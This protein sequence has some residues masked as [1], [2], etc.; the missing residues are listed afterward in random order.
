MKSQLGSVIH[1]DIVSQIFYVRGKKVMIDSDLASLYG[2]ETKVLNQAVKRNLKRFPEDFCFQL[3]S[4]EWSFLRSQFVTL[5]K[6]SLDKELK[7]DQR[8][9]FR[10]YLPFVFTEHGTLMLASVLQS[11]VA[12]NASIFVVRAFIKLREFLEINKDLK[13]KVETLEAKYDK[14]FMLLFRA[15]K[16][17]VQ[18]KNDPLAP[19]GFRIERDKK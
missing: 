3:K 17:L 9:R 19:I 2:V 6:S 7:A 11:E 16:E 14:Q 10:K 12:I 1:Q 18:K 8:G 5:E 13:Q 4:D 15:I